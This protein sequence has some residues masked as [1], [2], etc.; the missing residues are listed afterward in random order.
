MPQ[1]QKGMHSRGFMGARPSPEQEAAVV[2]FHR[3]LA[4]YMGEGAPEPIR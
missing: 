3:T 1:V 2:N 4:Q